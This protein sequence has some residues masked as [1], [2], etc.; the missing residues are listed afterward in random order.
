MVGGA[1]DAVVAPGA[2]DVGTDMAAFEKKLTGSAEAVLRGTLAVLGCDKMLVGKTDTV[3]GGRPLTL[4]GMLEGRA[5]DTAVDIA[6]ELAH[7]L[8]LGAGVLALPLLE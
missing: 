7:T 6:I 3:V 5:V 1:T 4:T 2:E 8:L